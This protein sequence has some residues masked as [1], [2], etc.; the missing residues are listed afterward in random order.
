MS[1]RSWIA[2]ANRLGVYLGSYKGYRMY[3]VQEV[4]HRVSIVERDGELWER[5]DIIP[6]KF[7]AIDKNGSRATH[8]FPFDLYVAIDL[9]WLQD[10]YQ[11][12]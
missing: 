1:R 5:T 11:T 7:I 4:T 9:Q 6:G 2:D 12:K 3:C 8:S 10:Y